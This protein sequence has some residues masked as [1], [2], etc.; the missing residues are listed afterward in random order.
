[1]NF[2]RTAGTVLFVSTLVATCMYALTTSLKPPLGDPSRLLLVGNDANEH[3]QRTV[4]GARAA[5]RELGIELVVETPT[6]HE[7]SEQQVSLVQRTN[8]ADYGGVAISPAGPQL[9]VEFLNDLANRTKLVTVD[10]D[11]SKLQRL[12]YVGYSQMNAGRL[13]ARL[14][15]EQLKRQGK[16]VLLA[17]TFSDDAL[18]SSVCERTAGFKETWASCAQNETMPCPIVEVTTDSDLSATLVDP[19]VATIIALDARAAESALKALAAMSYPRLVPIFSFD[20]NGAILD[21]I[22]DGRV[23]SAIFD[24][25]YRSGFTAIQRL[26]AYRRTDKY[27]LPVPGHGSDFLVGEVVNKENVADFRRRT[28]S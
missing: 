27:S 4:A 14:V 17:T 18:N 1:M 9:Q 25:P 16:V 28:R 13:V 3:W 12:C 8:F 22:E 23:C 21:A 24:D 15:G 20:L 11:D 10:R 6:S 5:A 2:F 19:E 7:S 26:A